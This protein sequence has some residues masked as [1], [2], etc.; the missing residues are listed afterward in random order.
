MRPA[1]DFFHMQLSNS[2]AAEMTECRM[3]WKIQ[4]RIMNV[5]NARIWVILNNAGNCE[6]IIK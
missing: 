3:E 5:Q 2:R 4:C 6:D 1:S